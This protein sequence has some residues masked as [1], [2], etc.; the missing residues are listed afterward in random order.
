MPTHKQPKTHQITDAHVTPV[1]CGMLE[2]T[3]CRLLSAAFGNLHGLH[4]VNQKL[5]AQA[6]PSGLLMT[7][8]LRLVPSELKCWHDATGL[9]D[10]I[11]L[12]V[13]M[14]TN[15]MSLHC[16]FRAKNVLV[17]SMAAQ[18]TPQQAI[19]SGKPNHCL[20]MCT[21]AP[22]SCSPQHTMLG[23]YNLVKFEVTPQEKSVMI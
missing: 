20:M 16:S 21:W 4:L 6:R 19:V 17:D 15:C 14:Y 8:V 2:A 13:D 1:A 12:G 22:V 3:R 10:R 7:V 11:E 5:T 9:S 23:T 18:P